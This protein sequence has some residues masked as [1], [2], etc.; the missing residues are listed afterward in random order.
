MKLVHALFILLLSILF[1][2]CSIVSSVL[3]SPTD[4]YEQDISDLTLTRQQQPN[5][6]GIAALSTALS[7]WNIDLNIEEIY[8]NTPP[9]AEVGYSLSELQDITE[10]YGA[11]FVAVNADYAFIARQTGLKRPVLIPVFRPREMRATLFMTP[12]AKE[13]IV[14]LWWRESVTG[15]LNHYLVVLAANEEEVYLFDPAFG[16]FVIAKDT[17]ERQRQQWSTIAALPFTRS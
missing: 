5:D 14:K 17:F 2:G 16:D 15:P 4:R 13:Q 11:N 3:P 6:C 7:A 9:S 8:E 12:A 1:T 10:S